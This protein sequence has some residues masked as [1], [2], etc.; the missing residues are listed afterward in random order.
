MGRWHGAAQAWQNINTPASADQGGDRHSLPHV[1][2]LSDLYPVSQLHAHAHAYA[3]AHQDADAKAHQDADAKAHQDGASHVFA[4]AD[5]HALSRE[6]HLYAL[7]QRDGHASGVSDGD[8]YIGAWFTR[9]R[10][11]ERHAPTD[12]YRAN[13]RRFTTS[14]G[15]QYQ[16]HRD[17]GGSRRAWPAT[18]PIADDADA[19]GL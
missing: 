17:T 7:P 5:V 19:T 4:F 14:S 12:E 16:R 15:T 18:R 8:R 1:H 11:G 6:S 10:N 3:E 2:A 9:A 13:A